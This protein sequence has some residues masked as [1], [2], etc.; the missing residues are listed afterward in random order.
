MIRRVIF[1]IVIYYLLSAIT[2][3]KAIDIPIKKN[4]LVGA[5]SY[6]IENINGVKTWMQFPIIDI[7]GNNTLNISFDLLESEQRQLYFSIK[8]MEYDWT[9]TTIPLSQYLSG[10]NRVIIA[11]PE[12][13]SATLVNYCHYNISLNSKNTELGISLS[14]NYLI[15]VF[16]FED[17]TNPLFEIPFSVIKNKVR[18]I[19]EKSMPFNGDFT[20][21]QSLNISVDTSNIQIYNPSRNIKIVV[22]QNGQWENA[23]ILREP[24]LILNN[25]ICYCES[26]AALFE[27]GNQF[28]KVEHLA[29]KVVG[30]G[31][32]R[33]FIDQ[34]Y[35]L[36]LFD[37]YNRSQ[38]DYTYEK[39]QCGRQIIHNLNSSTESASTDYQLLHFTFKSDYI[40]DG[41]L[42][43][44]GEAF[45]FLPYEY[46]KLTY[47]YEKKEYLLSVLLKMGYQEYKYIVK[48]PDG[49]TYKY[50][51]GNHYQTSNEYSILVY[52]SDNQFNSNELIGYAYLRINI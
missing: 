2:P 19:V 50:T 41:D 11:L 5:V 45:R 31:V 35:N 39:D 9:P 40:K 23:I 33:I 14:G 1:G 34:I 28:Y 8:R 46:K 3:L 4:S 27:G 52:N 7:S 12:P 49:I 47:N 21:T 42:L 26:K 10:I 13:S 43:I 15:S 20:T 30:L 25:K 18:V 38:K 36:S 44:E 22:L 24:S 16:S 17:N 51:S 48:T 6:N 29:D 32:E 37:N